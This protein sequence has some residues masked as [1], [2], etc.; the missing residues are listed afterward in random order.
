MP[1]GAPRLRSED[2]KLNLVGPRVQQ[3]RDQLRLKQDELCARIAMET[4]GAWSPG[5]Q[6]LSRIENGARIVSDV[7][8]VLLAKV[9]ECSPCWLLAGM[10]PRE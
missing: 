4:Q 10:M 6:D 7:E 9:L 5:W 1:R 8:V 3:R 2:Q